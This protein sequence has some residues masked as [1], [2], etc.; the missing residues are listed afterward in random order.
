MA[1]RVVGKTSGEIEETLED[2]L[3]E[4]ELRLSG[5]ELR[6]LA[7]IILGRQG[8]S[9]GGKVRAKNLSQE[10]KSEIA[11]EAAQARWGKSS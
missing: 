11:R 6:K 7:A 1:A 3:D 8:G 4:L 2:I 10:R 9:V 5:D